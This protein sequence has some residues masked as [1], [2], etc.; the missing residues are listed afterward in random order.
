[1]MTTMNT[2]EAPATEVPATATRRTFTKEYKLRVLE[3]ADRCTG[4]GEVGKLL[5]GEG[6]YSSHLTAWRRQR[7]EGTLKALAK[8]RGPKVKKSA[9]QREVD[10]LRRENARLRRKLDHAEK[11]IGVQKKLSEVLGIQFEEDDDAR[12]SD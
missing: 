4:G 11:I 2:T 12:E 3:R 5:R 8:R 1:M 9:E 6:L 10:D 7:R